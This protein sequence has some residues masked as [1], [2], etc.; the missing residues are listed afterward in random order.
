MTWSRFDD[1]APKHP[2]S[3]AAGNEAWALWAAAVMYCNRFHTDGYVTLASL[4]SECL[5]EPI[6][7]AKA[8][9]LAERLCGARVREDG[10]G[11]FENAGK[12]R[13]RV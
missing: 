5:P 9:K 6:S 3:Q 2:K 1:A 11:L 7:L 8:R 13:F 12:D 10:G 4:A